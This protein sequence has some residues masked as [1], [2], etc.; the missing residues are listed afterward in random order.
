M[1][2]PS[3]QI[4][5][6]HPVTGAVIKV[7]DAQAFYQI[8]YS[9]VYNGIGAIALTLPVDRMPSAAFDLTDMFIE[10]QRTSPIT[11]QLI[12]EETYLARS[13]RRYR[14]GVDER[15]TIGGL[16]L[17]H[18][19][20]RRVVDPADDPFAAGGFST[21]AGA[22]DVVLYQYASEQMSVLASAPRQFPGLSIPGVYAVAPSVGLRLQYDNLFQI[23]Q[24][25]CQQVGIDFKI[26]RTSGVNTE[27]NIGYL[28]VNRTQSAN[29]PVT[30]FVLL[31]PQRGNLS[32]PSFLRDRTDEQ[33][34]VYMQGKGQ[35]SSRYT[36]EWQDSSATSASP[37]NR[38]EFAADARNV[39]KGDSLGILSEAKD[40]LKEKQ[41]V[42]KFDFEPEGTRP[43]N[44]YRQN[45]DVGDLITATWD[46]NT[47]NLRILAV[48]MNVT[49]SGEYLGITTQVI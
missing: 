7:F 11:G 5:F 27:L 45:W 20:A 42:I 28:T 46:S 48:E 22:A 18:L 34:F 2:N 3:Y 21:K 10:V 9:R 43:G 4:V 8:R 29:Y 1:A 6:L 13:W 24:Q 47:A 49:E 40:A 44:I 14:L 31:T 16:S 26:S 25:T 36:I 32:N 39:E 12:A 17:N 41:Q 35:G 33:N 38:I 30:P 15:Y 19:L 23:F 37:F